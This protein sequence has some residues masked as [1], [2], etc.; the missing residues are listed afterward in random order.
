MAG[1]RRF[2]RPKKTSPFQRVPV[3]ARAIAD[4]DLYG[5]PWYSK[6]VVAHR[7]AVLDALPFADQP[8]AGDRPVVGAAAGACA[9]SPPSS[10]SASAS[11]RFERLGLEPAIGQFLNP[12]GQPAFEEAPVVGRRLGLEEIAPLAASDRGVGA[13]FRAA[14]RAKNGVGHVRA[15]CEL[16]VGM[17]AL[18]RARQSSELSPPSADNGL[19]F[20]ARR[21]MR[22]AARISPISSSRSFGR[23]ELD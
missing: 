7:H 3:M 6:S 23:S 2:L 15:S 12:V 18:V 4:S 13:V 21:R 5:R 16:G 17:T 10:S 8:R 1:A 14:T 11:S 22:P 19:D 20:R 9:G